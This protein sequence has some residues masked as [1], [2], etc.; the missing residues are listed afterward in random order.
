MFARCEP[1][2]DRGRP[3]GHQRHARMH[4][5][6]YS[7]AAASRSDKAVRRG[8]SCSDAQKMLEEKLCNRMP[9]EATPAEA[10]HV[11]L[12]RLLQ[13]TDPEL[14]ERADGDLTESCKPAGGSGYGAKHR[15]GATARNSCRQASA[16]RV[17][18]AHAITDMRGVAASE[19]DQAPVRG[20]PPAPPHPGFGLEPPSRPEPRGCH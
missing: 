1:L 12:H 3:A 17:V 10:R 20:R 11:L 7:E 8:R 15:D 16:L 4:G 14:K 19:K 6:T 18:E 9:A 13:E 5:R 2:P